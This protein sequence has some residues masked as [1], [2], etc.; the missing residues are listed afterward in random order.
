[1]KKL[2][3]IIKLILAF[4][5]TFSLFTMKNVYAEE[6]V[7]A[8]IGDKEYTSFNDALKDANLNDNTTIELLSNIYLDNEKITISSDKNIIID[9]QSYTIELI[10]KSINNSGGG[11]VGL[12][13][14]SS[15]VLKNCQVNI[16]DNLS[17]YNGTVAMNANTE[18]TLDNVNMTID[19]I[20]CSGNA[21]G[22]YL[23]DDN[24]KGV[25]NVINQ[26][27]L[28]VK[29]YPQDAL[30]WDGNGKDE[31]NVSNSTVNFSNNR[32]GIAGTINCKF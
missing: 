24:G 12:N 17:G 11:L 31:F 27:Q 23:W 25:I 28:N 3:K 16:K 15:L 30:E 7:V 22:I 21:H 2:N 32:S 4:A 5:F 10:Y 26:S 6:T 8:K 1:M 29:N 20:N 19:G 14:N 18:L 13:N 9:G